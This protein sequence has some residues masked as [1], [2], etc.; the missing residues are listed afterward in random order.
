M[1]TI[2]PDTWDIFY[3][4]L[5][6]ESDYR[7]IFVI[8]DGMPDI[9]IKELGGTPLSAAQTPNL[10]RLAKEGASGLIYPTI[11][12]HIPVGSGPA[13][14][15]L[16]GYGLD[17]YPGRGALEALGAGLTVPQGSIVIRINFATIDENGIVIDRRAG[18][19]RD[20]EAKPLM[21]RLNGLK[22]EKDW[23]LDYKIHHT[24]GYRGALIISGEDASAAISNSDP[25]AIGQSILEVVPLSNEKTAQNTANFINWFIK[26]AQEA[27]AKNNDTGATGIVT[28][29]AGAIKFYES[30]TDRYKFKSPIFISSYPL[31]KGIARF[32][33][34]PVEEPKKSGKQLTIN[35]K[36]KTAAS[37]IKKHDMT[38]L[39][40][41]DP[42][43]AG[44][45]GNSLRKK[46][47]IEE[48]DACIPYITDKMEEDDT[49]VI[50]SDHSTPAPMREHSGHPIPL[51]MKGP[52]VRVD[53]VEKFSELD[54]IHGSLGTFRAIE[55]MNLILM[56]TKR[57]KIYGP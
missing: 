32:L 20:N 57:L 37:L 41:K 22:C 2:I 10:D 12:P 50:T 45:D 29:G 17:R 35:D 15:A 53:R 11:E 31:Y 44:E 21:E 51:L 5:V 16:F 40:I 48:I 6:R 34:I 46:E 56:S 43:T 52:F 26:A 39:H 13:H 9:H 28:R 49:L 14:L 47:I 3:K 7:V 25:R 30:F 36:C 24:K 55:L 18:R 23:C 1:E 38:I 33:R 4:N 54:C 27:L 19:L 8:I 42:D